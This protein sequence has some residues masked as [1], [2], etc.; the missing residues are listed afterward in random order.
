MRVKSVVA[1]LLVFVFALSVVGSGSAVK[2]GDSYTYSKETHYKNLYINKLAFESTS[3]LTEVKNGKGYIFSVH[4]KGYVKS[5]RGKHL[6]L[7]HNYFLTTKYYKNYKLVKTVKQLEKFD[8]YLV[9][10]KHGYVPD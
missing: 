1:V 5:I 9:L 3:V 2:N 4:D 10:T 8:E 6:T 7:R